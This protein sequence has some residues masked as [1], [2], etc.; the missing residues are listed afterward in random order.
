[1]ALW[2]SSDNIVS[3]GIVTLSKVGDDWIVSGEEFEAQFGQTAV[4]GAT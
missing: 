4:G 3:A 1:M 2:G